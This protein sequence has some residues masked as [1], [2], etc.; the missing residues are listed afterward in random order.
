[1]S[2]DLTK[3]QRKA[4]KAERK[5]E[6]A[7]S[8]AQKQT[9]DSYDRNVVC[10]KY[11]DKY[12]SNYVNRLYNMVKRHTTGTVGFFC[13]TENPVGLDPDIKIIPLPEYKGLQGWWYKP[14]V[15]NKNLPIKGK[16]LF[17]DLDIVIIR[18]ID[19]FFDYTPNKF[20]IIRDFTRSLNSAW[21]RYNS[22]V[23]RL[24]SGKLD[25]VWNDLISDISVTK[26]LHGDQ[27]WIYEKIK[28]DFAFWPDD[29]CQSYKWEIRNRTEIVGVGRQRNFSTILHEPKIKDDTKI[30]VFHGDPKPDQVKDPIVV[31]NWV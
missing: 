27:D 14:F 13:M 21:N 4:L 25:Y 16:I 9:L 7:L 28:T 19:C 11:G 12:S 1:M 23:F 3:A 5:L 18:N 8:K 29:W 10:L 30:L 22:S 15:F 6:K 20:C 2:E 24:D 26:R 17:L 31:T